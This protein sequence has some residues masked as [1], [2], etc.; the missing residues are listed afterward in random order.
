MVLV[1]VIL[2]YALIIVGFLLLWHEKVYRE[3]EQVETLEVVQDRADAWE[4]ID[5][6]RERHPLP[7]AHAELEVDGQ[8][9][10]HRNERIVRVR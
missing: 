4:G 6:A 8:I 9:H 2:G 7:A 1:G 10:L 5:R 3:P